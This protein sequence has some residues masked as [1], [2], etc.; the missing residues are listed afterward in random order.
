MTKHDDDDRSA[1][2]V[3]LVMI[4]ATIFYGGLMLWGAIS[5]LNWIFQ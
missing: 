2:M 3:G 4:A 5:I 1:E